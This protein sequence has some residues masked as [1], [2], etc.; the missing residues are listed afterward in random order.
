MTCHVLH[1]GDGYTYLTRQVASGDVVRAAH[2]PLVEYY[3]QAGNPPGQWAGSGLADLG[4]FGEVTEEQMLAL[5]GEGLH[6]NANP[7]IAAQVADGKTYQEGLQAA[8]LGRRFAQYDITIPLVKA[9]AAA[10]TEFEEEHGRRPS[11][12][13]RRE[14][15]ETTARALLVEARPDSPPP[16]RERVR[17]FITDELGRARQPVAGFDLVFSPVKSVSLLWALGGHEIRRIVEEIHE[18]AWCGAIAYGEREAAFTR[19]GAG[20][21]AQVATHGFVI[22]AFLHRESRAGDPDLHTHVTVSNRVLADDGKWR[23]IDGQQLFKVAVSMSETYNALVEQG[24]VER[25]GAHF[26]DVSRGAGKRTVREIV[27]MPAEWIRGFSRRRTQVEAGYDRLV[28]EYVRAHGHAPPRSVQ[29]QLA[30]QATLQ[31]RPTKDT[32]R[33]LAEQIADWTAY[34]YELLPG[35]SIPTAIGR[36]VGHRP[37]AGPVG[38][39]PAVA[40]AV[41]D[42]VAEDRSTWTVYHV[43]A[44]A[45][46]QLRAAGFPDAAQRIQAVEAVTQLA[47]GRES[48]LLDVEVDR[49]PTLLRRPDGESVFRRRGAAR[50]TSEEL[51]AA[52]ADLLADAHTLRGPVVSRRAREAAIR[53]SER[54]RPGRTRLNAGQRALVEHFTSSGA[55]LAVAIGPPGAGKSTAMAAVRAAWETT[56]GRVLGFAPSAAAASVLGDELGVRAD[57]L[58]S[59]ITARDNNAPIDIAAG[60][61]L[62]VDEAG[63]AG[64]LAL[65]ELRELAEERGA[66]LRL[67][68]DH[69]Q[70]PAIEA[71]GALRLLHTDAGGIELSEVHRFANPDEAAAILQFRVGD[72]RSIAFYADNNRLVGGVR[73]AV[74]DQLYSHW[75]ADVAAGRTA[76]MIS[77]STEIARELSARAQTERRAAG[78]VEDTGTPLHD[79]TVA[80]VGDRIVTRLNR[81]RLAV[82]GGRDFVKNGDL[83]EVQKRHADGRLRVRHVGHHGRITLPAWYV[84]EWVELGYAATIHR[85]QGLTVDIARSFLTAAAVREAALV[86]LSRGIDGNYAYF[87]IQ[88]I[89]HPDEPDTLPGDLYYRH[90]ET[91]LAERALHA[92]LERE[93]AELSATETLRDALESPYRLST[94]IPEYTYGRHVHRGPEAEQQAE[95]WIHDAMPTYAADILTDN[96]WPALQHLLHELHDNGGDPVALL[97]A[98]AAERELYTDPTDPAQSIAKVMHYRIVADLPTPAFDDDRR[99][100]LLPGWVTT[101]PPPPA[102]HD[103]PDYAELAGWL[104]ARAD[105]IAGRVHALGTRATQHQPPWTR[106][107]GDVPTTP[108]GQEWWIRRAGHVAAYRERWQI[109]DTNPELLPVTARGEQARARAWVLDYLNRTAAPPPDS[110]P[111]PTPQPDFAQ[112]TARVRDQLAALRAALAH[113]F[114]T[115][116]PTPHPGVDPGGADILVADPEQDPAAEADIPEPYEETDADLDPDL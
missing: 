15:K 8:R 31:D 11:V 34:A 41:V 10:Y 23:T 112:R 44:E 27:G 26:E 32:L 83:W 98:R 78:Q 5:F 49:A 99:P 3:Q 87:D 16:S 77:D 12:D 55:A 1:A 66:V 89:L 28:R 74:L 59:L 29:W 85:S 113:P 53:A 47:L 68:G 25:L 84:A 111:A 114:T 57:T 60:D 46:R 81:R 75:Q 30:Q 56:G 54:S 2:D 103:H 52:E 7:F 18:Q 101:P 51:L 91:T 70:L 6:P 106:P 24:I 102:V 108:D 110:Q 39:L 50:Y 109:P 104:R 116:D 94:V 45:H 21:I 90:R 33:T 97:R 13:E 69:R 62:L 22:A 58:H 88:E 40:A 82:L 37:D 71:G 96:A 95:Q 67:V 38:D 48:I 86:A 4:V 36:C 80:G 72:P 19:V 76:I 92:I 14:L 43:R 79:G 115:D 65:A 20:G 17:Q 105:Q 63:M 64:T 9:V 42:R 93:G 100:L 73:A 35:H 107:L 61:M